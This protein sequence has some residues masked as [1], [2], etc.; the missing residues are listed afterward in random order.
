MSESMDRDG[1]SVF[2]YF[3][4]FIIVV[5]VLDIHEKVDE[6]YKHIG[7]DKPKPELKRPVNEDSGPKQLR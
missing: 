1:C 7:L 2:A 6:I 5:V 4:L 3:G